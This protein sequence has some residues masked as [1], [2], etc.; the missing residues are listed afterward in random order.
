MHSMNV[1]LTISTIEI[2]FLQ[3]MKLNAWDI[4]QLLSTDRRMALICSTLLCRIVDEI[5]AHEG[6][7]RAGPIECEE[8][9][10]DEVA[11]AAI[12]LANPKQRKEIYLSAIHLVAEDLEAQQ[13][14][15]EFC[16]VE[17]MH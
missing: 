1:P 8:R 16:K 2:R 12:L 5:L 6:G 9:L 7:R 17:R 15:Q 11:R 14:L 3:L 10:T 13:R 4:A